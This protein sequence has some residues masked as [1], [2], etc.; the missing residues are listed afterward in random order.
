MPKPDWLVAR[1]AQSEMERR[2]KHCIRCKHR[3]PIVGETNYIDK[4]FKHQPVYQCALHPTVKFH[5]FTLAC[6]DY[7]R[8][9]P[10][11]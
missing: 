2:L 6:T 10:K 3:G 5:L 9:K 7:E 1:E 8:A 11:L 4:V